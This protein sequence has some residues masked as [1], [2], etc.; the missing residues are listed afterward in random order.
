[1]S[2]ASGRDGRFSLRSRRMANELAYKIR[3]EQGIKLED[4]KLGLPL[5]IASA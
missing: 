1:M 3:E 5:G 4:V 2:L